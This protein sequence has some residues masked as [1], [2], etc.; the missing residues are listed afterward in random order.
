MKNENG[1]RMSA[2]AVM[3]A[4]QRGVRHGLF[5]VRNYTH[6][7]AKFEAAER[8]ELRGVLHGR[9]ETSDF[10]AGWEHG[11][12]AYVMPAERL[13]EIAAANAQVRS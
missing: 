11:Y 13:A 10:M 12:D 2:S 3:N 7:D 4:F 8:L 9:Q 5:A 6:V 1:W